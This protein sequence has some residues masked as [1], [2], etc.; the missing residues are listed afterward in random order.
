[1]LVKGFKIGLISG[2]IY[3]VVAIALTILFETLSYLLIARAY[4]TI[5]MVQWL[6]HR[7]PAEIP[8]LL[9]SG[10]VGG[11]LFGVVYAVLRVKKP[12]IASI[13][14][15]FALALILWVTFGVALPRIFSRGIPA[16]VN[17]AAAVT[18]GVSLEYLWDR[19]S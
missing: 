11:V 10:L 19:F 14:I 2:L 18:Y 15:S 12:T 5:L 4:F 1:M 7:L 16:T 3:S 13:N 8:W 17:L 6:L 9:E